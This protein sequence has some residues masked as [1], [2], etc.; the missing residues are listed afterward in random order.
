MNSLEQQKNFLFGSLEA[1]KNLEEKD[2]ASVIVISDSHKNYS[3]FK[4]VLKKFGSAADALIFCGDGITDILAAFK[5]ALTDEYFGAAIPPV[6]GVVEGNN[7]CDMYP[8]VNKE[9]F[10]N[11]DLPFYIQVKIPLKNTLTVCSHKIFFTHGHHYGIYSGTDSLLDAAKELDC[12]IAL[13]GHTHLPYNQFE[14]P[15]TMILN[16]G[17][18]SLPRGGHPCTF[19][20]L[21]LKKNSDFVDFTFFQMNGSKFTP[22]I[23][24]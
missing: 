3:S 11:P 8:M 20:V 13:F 1:I 15:R 18:I 6:V 24:S 10:K 21:N 14:K 19:A 7:D 4:Q 17:S 5:D 2:S 23:P 9:Y 22:Y 16:P 12:D